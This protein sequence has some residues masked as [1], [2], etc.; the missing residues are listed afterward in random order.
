MELPNEGIPAETIFA[1][2]DNLQARRRAL[3]RRSGVQLVYYGGAGRVGGGR[4]GVPQLLERERVEHRR[5]PRPAGM[6]AKSFRSSV[7]WLEAGHEGAGFMTTG[8]T[9]SILMAVKAARER[10]R[11]E[12]AITAP[13]VVLPASAHAAFEKA[14]PL[15]RCREP[16]RR[17]RRR[18]ACGRRRDGG[19]HRRQ[20]R[21][22]RRLGAAVS[23]GR[24]RPDPR[25]RRARRRARHQCHVDACMGGVTLTYMAG[26]ARW[27]RR[28]T[29]RCPASRASRST[30][31]STAT[32]P[33]ARR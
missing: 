5:V 6:Q 25:D 27:C 14:L 3:A 13:N 7:E 18:L 23:A 16:A 17:G 10:G 19:R 2:L 32:R 22:A 8:G 28:G 20:H 24:D 30:C 11:K 26:S 9:E 1:H 12:R 31:T 15:L 4:R 29:S 21:V 33:R